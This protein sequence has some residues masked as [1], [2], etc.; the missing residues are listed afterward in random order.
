MGDFENKTFLLT[1]VDFNRDYKPRLS[2]G[3]TERDEMH[4]FIPKFEEP[5]SIEIDTTK[6]FCIGWHDLRTGESFLCPDSA[7]VD[8]KYEQCQNCQKR[9]GFNPAFY[10]ANAGDISNQQAERNSQPHFVYL[11]YFSK[12]TIK[13]GISFSGRKLARLL[14]QGA[15]A[16]LILGEFSSANVA[17]NY[18]EKI[19]KMPIFCEN[20]KATL[21]LK[22]IENK[23]NFSDASR[24]LLEAREVIEKNLKTKFDNNQ[25]IDFSEF[26]SKTGEIP[27]REMISVFD[28]NKT[29]ELKL[30]FSGILK[31]QIGYILIV[32]QQDE[33]ITIP[34]KKF[35]GYK[36]KLSNEIK[37]LELP[38]RQASFFDLF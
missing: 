15:R 34:L 13:V 16:A 20:V 37:T 30:V 6:R 29:E 17:R 18:E 1:R 4:D 9:T 8:K 27:S 10:N 5:I 32:Q 25:P 14:E 22:L 33:F 11:A 23:F 38:E 7:E 3:D 19:S 12:E 21:K 35:T 24:S 2:L 26:Y 31:A 36:I 28:C